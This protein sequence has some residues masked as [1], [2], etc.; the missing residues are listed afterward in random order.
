MTDE[1]GQ[2]TAETAAVL[3]VL[4]L[5]TGMLLWGLL[6]TVSYLQ[7]VDAARVGARAAARGDPPA[8][9]LALAGRSA[10]RG[11]RVRLEWEG[12]LVRVRVSA[13]AAGPGALAVELSAEAVARVEQPRSSVA[14]GAADRGGRSRV[15]AA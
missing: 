6:A 12:E 10:P 15:R 2:A 11:S 14:G 3:P 7:C 4:V 9:V 13:R 8:E 5:L 1:R